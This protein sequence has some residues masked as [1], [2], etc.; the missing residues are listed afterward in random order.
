MKTISTVII[1]I[2]LGCSGADD[3][4]PMGLSKDGPD[5]LTCTVCECPGQVCSV[6]RNGVALG[7]H[8]SEELECSEPCEAP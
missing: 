8:C 7:G 1:T 4:E 3:C 5:G 6:G 2:L